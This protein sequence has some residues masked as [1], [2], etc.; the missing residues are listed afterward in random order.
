M[1]I[2]SKN[3]IFSFCLA[4]LILTLTFILSLKYV[5]EN[6]KLNIS[7]S[8]KNVNLL[9]NKGKKVSDLNFSGSPVLLFFGFT[10]C[11]EICPSILSKLENIIYE[12]RKLNDEIKIV[13]VTLD[14]NRD[15]V[16]ALNDYISSFDSF[17]IGITGKMEELNK[18]AKYWNVYWEKVPYNKDD[19][20]INHTATVFML[21][22]KGDFSGTISWGESEAST[23]IKIR[24][25]IKNVS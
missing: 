3:F 11:P 2:L 5:N 4:F 22:S 9:T 7:Q 21:D 15:T 10:H 13:F 25:L 8:L 14:P 6:S 12:E 1:N 24:N 20:N 17:V 19:Y 23:R 16:E 18:L